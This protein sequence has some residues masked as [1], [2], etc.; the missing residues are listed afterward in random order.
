MLI[1]ALLIHLCGGRIETH[2]IIFASLAFLAFYQ[3]WS[4]IVTASVVVAL[5]H[6]IRGLLWPRSIYGVLT[7]SPWRWVEHSGWVLFEDI[8][9]IRACVQTLRELRRTALQQAQLEDR[10][11]QMERIVLIRTDELRLANAC[12]LHEIAERQE[13]EKN[14][15]KTED[16]AGAAN[17][18][19]DR[20]P[21]QHES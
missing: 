17:R 2:F 14:L 11:H 16:L 15:Q 4:V 18:G 12:L 5:D 8:F 1:G 10:R 6:A 9:L 21:G 19:Q 20:V 7:A 3:D 13:V